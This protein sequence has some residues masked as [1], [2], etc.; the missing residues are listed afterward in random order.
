MEMG[1]TSLVV[2]ELHG[3]NPLQYSLPDRTASLE[4]LITPRVGKVVEQLECSVIVDGSINGKKILTVSNKAQYVHTLWASKSTR[5]CSPVER[6]TYTLQN[7]CT[8]LFI[9]V[10]FAIAQSGTRLICKWP[11]VYQQETPKQTLQ[12]QCN[13]TM[14]YYTAIKVSMLQLHST[15]INLQDV[16]MSKKK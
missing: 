2:R 10:L 16:I 12:L 6:D 4:S 1:S 8:R 14:F 5:G 15:Q 13:Y 9:A 3:K 11:N 7:V